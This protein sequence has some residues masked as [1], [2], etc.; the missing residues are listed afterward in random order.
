[1]GVSRIYL[2]NS[3]VIIRFELCGRNKL[4]ASLN[5]LGTIQGGDGVPARYLQPLVQTGE[6]A[7][8]LGLDDVLVPLSKMADMFVSLV[9]LLFFRSFAFLYDMFSTLVMLL[10]QHWN[11]SQTTFSCDRFSDEE[12]RVHLNYWHLILWQARQE[13]WVDGRM[14]PPTRPRPRR[15]T[16]VCV[17]VGGF[18]FVIPITPSL[19]SLNL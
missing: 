10:E 8:L 1:M 15:W 5:I 7:E 19:C 3:F 17:L 13:R 12:I 2:W 18:S 14:S 11:G 16:Q 4:H 9:G 6:D